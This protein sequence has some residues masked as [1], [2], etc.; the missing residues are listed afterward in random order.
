MPRPTDDR[1]THHFTRRAARCAIA[2]VIALAVLPGL[3]SAATVTRSADGTLVYTAA[4]GEQNALSVQVGY[5]ES[6][7]VLYQTGTPIDEAVPDGCTRDAWSS[8]VTV[9]CPNPPALLVDLGDG[10]DSMTQTLGLKVPVTA[11]GGSGND[12]LSGGDGVEHFDGGPGNDKL[13]TAGGDDTLLGG[14]GNDV[15]EGKAGRDHL[16]GGAGDDT[17]RPDG[18]EDAS[19]DFVDG[20]PGTDLID[21]DYTSRF[22]DSAQRPPVAITL[23]GGADDGRPGEGDDLRGIEQIALSIGGSVTGTDGPEVI[24]FLQVGTASRV[25]AGGGDDTVVT[26]D[27]ADTI[28]GGAGDDDIDAGY[29]DD[30]IVPGPGRDKVSADNR[31]GDCGPLWCKF[32]HGDDTVDARD[33]EVDHIDCG[34]GTDTVQADPQD[35]VDPD[36]ENVTRSGSAAGG[37]AP[38]GGG[39]GSASHTVALRIGATGLAGALARGLRVRVSGAKPGAR[40][41]LSAKRGRTILARG[42]GRAGRSGT[43]TVTLRFT[44][45]GKRALRAARSVRLTITGGGGRTV[46]TLRRATGHG[47]RVA[48]AGLPS[49]LDQRTFKVDVKG[50]QTTT[51]TLDDPSENR[52]DPAISGSGSERVSFRTPKP[53]S[54]VV[55]RYGANYVIA[56][57]PFALGGNDVTTRAVVT[58]N[59]HVQSTAVDPDCGDNGGADPGMPDPDCG[60]K[61]T[62]FPVALGYANEPRHGF[63]LTAA[64]LPTLGDLFKNCPWT[65][66][67][68]AF[69]HL[70]EQQGKR[71]VVAGIPVADLFNRA[72]GQQIAIGRGVQ[73]TNSGGMRTTTRIRWDVRLT[74]AKGGS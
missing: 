21:S 71:P 32:P 35:V 52:C 55:K 51:W 50:V 40:V 64:D 26:G 13:S 68:I 44:A 9:T 31:G 69:P 6:T 4:P 16:E 11:A 18:Y 59:G 27:G 8:T 61:R 65:G 33:G 29:G 48:R 70:L 2:S 1:R 46:A 5:D 72:Y 7:T 25:D 45:G 36:C 54:L 28:D 37:P 24:R 63:T 23:S 67:Q 58:R 20:G 10:D 41:V 12:T 73:R 38:A 74:R 53:L 62:S 56:G 60:T 22:V 30:T 49:A 15:L 47:A 57:D 14:D 19:G 34:F 43:V 3:A 66:G 42:S 17:L 39:S